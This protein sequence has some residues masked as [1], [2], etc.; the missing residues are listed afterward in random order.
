M[1]FTRLLISHHSSYDVYSGD[2]SYG[3]RPRSPVALRHSPSCY[4]TRRSNDR[5]S[6]HRDPQDS[7]GISRVEPYE[8]RH[9]RFA[10]PASRGQQSSSERVS[11]LTVSQVTT[12]CSTCSLGIELKAPLRVKSYSICEL[13]FFPTGSPR[14]TSTP[15][16]NLPNNHINKIK[17]KLLHLP[18][19]LCQ[20]L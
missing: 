13:T 14:F 10:G 15:N 11:S 4:Y 17:P 20:P 1:L 5:Q 12:L 16:H 19:F 3:A 8:R 9:G 6:S 7:R 18:A 2:T